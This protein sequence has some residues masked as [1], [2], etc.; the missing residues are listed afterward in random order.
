MK[1]LRYLLLGGLIFLLI[2]LTAGCR[3]S[4]WEWS[5]DMAN[6]SGNHVRPFNPGDRAQR[7]DAIRPSVFFPRER[8][9]LTRR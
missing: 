2:F 3:T 6:Q 5:G 1:K 8:E 9:T 4:Y 7:N